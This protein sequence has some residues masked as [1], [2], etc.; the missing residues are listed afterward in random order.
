MLAGHLILAR[1]R[2]FLL[3]VLVLFLFCLFK[4]SLDLFKASLD[5]Y[6]LTGSVIDAVE[7]LPTCGFKMLG[8]KL[9]AAFF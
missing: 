5:R 1:V 7:M 6:F 2:W 4:V 3:D 8:T 9:S